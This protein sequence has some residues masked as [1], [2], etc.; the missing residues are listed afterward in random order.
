MII[1]ILLHKNAKVR[2]CLVPGACD[3]IENSLMHETA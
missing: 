3:H 2:V 1:D